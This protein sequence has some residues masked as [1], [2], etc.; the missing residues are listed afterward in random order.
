MFNWGNGGNNSLGGTLTV[1]DSTITG[2]RGTPRAAAAAAQASPATP[3]PDDLRLDDHG[4]H[5]RQLRRRRPQRHDHVTITD[6]VITGNSAAR[7][8]ACA[9]GP[10]PCRH[11]VTLDGNTATT[12]G[13]GLYN[14]SG[15]VT[16]ANTT[17]TGTPPSTAGAPC[18]TGGASRSTTHGR[19]Q[20]RHAATGAASTPRRQPHRST[21]DRANNVTEGANAQGGVFRQR[22]PVTIA[23]APSTATRPKARPP[24]AAAGCGHGR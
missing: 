14:Q 10:A 1:V 19:R 21:V 20:H 18:A 17:L 2:N 15:T 6:T 9:T 24:A 4:Q 5:G 22:R 13:G 8:V 16:V 7:V 12:E 23:T 11:G 3:A